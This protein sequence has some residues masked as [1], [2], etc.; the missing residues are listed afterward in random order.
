MDTGKKF[1]QV[2]QKD[3]LKKAIIKDMTPEIIFRRVVDVI[4]YDGSADG[5]PVAKL[6]KQVEDYIKIIDGVKE[7]FVN[8]LHL[9]DDNALAISNLNI[10]K[11]DKDDV[12]TKSEVKTLLDALDALKANKANTYTKDEVDSLFQAENRY[13]T[14]LQEKKADK[15]DTY[16]KGEIDSMRV[17]DRGRVYTKSEVDNLISIED[18]FITNLQ[19]E[20]ADKDDTYTK[21]EVDAG[22]GTKAEKSNTFTKAEVNQKFSDL[23]PFIFF[24]KQ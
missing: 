24:D 15:D 5:E 4:P 16:T 3:I 23:P 18:G 17:A 21:S 6:K 19:K 14:E 22:L 8:I 13:I 2:G 11:A 10:S 12:Y 20:K 7:S 9:I 1:I